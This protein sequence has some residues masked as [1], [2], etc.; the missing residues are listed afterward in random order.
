MK[1]YTTSNH[2]KYE[3]KKQKGKTTNLNG[4]SRKDVRI[5]FNDPI[6]QK[7]F[8]D[9]HN[10]FHKRHSDTRMYDMIDGD[11]ENSFQCTAL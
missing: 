1:F 7:H 8:Q 4:I 2:T 10:L 11:Q 6:I 3:Q 9:K 5:F